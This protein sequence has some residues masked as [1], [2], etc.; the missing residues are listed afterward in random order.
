MKILFQVINHCH[1]NGVVHR[2]LKPENIMLKMDSEE[3][4]PSDVKLIDF[5][6]CKVL[7]FNSKRN[8]YVN[9]EISGI[10]GT[11]YYSAP[12]VLDEDGKYGMACD[13]WSLGVILYILLSGHLPFPGTNNDDIENLIRVGQ[14]DFSHIEFKTVSEDGKD[15][16]TKL[17]CKDPSLRINCA[18]ALR[19]PWFSK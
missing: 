10:V 5:G 18:Q 9:G 16:I 17:L 3:I 12:E 1:A 13:Y 8:E 4:N 15:L 14:I 2:D 7:P 11:T 19:H 6:L